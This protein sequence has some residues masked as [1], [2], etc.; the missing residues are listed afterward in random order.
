MDLAEEELD[1][2]NLFFPFFA[3]L[4]LPGLSP[5]RPPPRIE[6]LVPIDAGVKVKDGAVSAHIKTKDNSF[7]AGV[8]VGPDGGS[9]AV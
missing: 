5:P 4:P 1:L 9:A 6:K 3:P 8:K 7:N 2:E